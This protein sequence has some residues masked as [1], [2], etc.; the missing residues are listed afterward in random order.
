MPDS[1]YTLEPLGNLRDVGKYE[2]PLKASWTIGKAQDL[3]LLCTPDL[4]QLIPLG[5]VALG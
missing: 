2:M 1:L 5:L 3:D 4:F